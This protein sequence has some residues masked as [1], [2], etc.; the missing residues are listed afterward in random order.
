MIKSNLLIPAVVL[1]V[2]I[3]AVLLLKNNAK[4]EFLPPHEFAYGMSLANISDLPEKVNQFLS[5]EAIDP[6]KVQKEIKV[7]KYL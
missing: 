7:K 1:I 5:L 4:A 2:V 3:I 6:D